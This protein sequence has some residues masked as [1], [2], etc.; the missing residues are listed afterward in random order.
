M[1]DPIEIAEYEAWKQSKLVGQIDLSVQ[2]Y[3]LE[4]EANALAWDEGW[5]ARD[6]GSGFDANRFRKPGMTGHKPPSRR[7][8]PAPLPVL[9]PLNEEDEGE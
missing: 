7:P 4:Q 3:N 9:G 1:L 2:A 5:L 6:A 8:A